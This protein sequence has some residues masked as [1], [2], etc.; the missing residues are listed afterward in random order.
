[1]QAAPEQG[2]ISRDNVR[3]QRIRSTLVPSSRLW[4]SL[5]FGL[6]CLTW[7]AKQATAQLWDGPNYL[8]S[9]TCRLRTV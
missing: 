7:M 9:N 5:F 1:M 2:L 4:T 6:C 3:G 8:Q